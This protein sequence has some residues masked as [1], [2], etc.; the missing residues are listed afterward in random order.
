[1]VAKCADS[2]PASPLPV[3][4]GPPH[5]PVGTG[6]PVPLLLCTGCLRDGGV[7]VKTARFSGTGPLCQA[8]LVPSLQHRPPV[9]VGAMESLQMTARSKRS[10]ASSRQ[11][12]L[13]FPL[14][15]GY[16]NHSELQGRGA[17]KQAGRYSGAKRGVPPSRGQ[18]SVVRKQP[19]GRI[20]E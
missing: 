13:G 7:T 1:M 8:R 16:C 5:C 12:Y 4:T 15:R 10:P 11:L 18:A 6:P 2:P 3:W 14:S 17:P 9:V 19:C 20:W